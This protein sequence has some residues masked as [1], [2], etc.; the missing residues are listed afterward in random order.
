MTTSITIVTPRARA[1]K[2]VRR[3]AD[4]HKVAI[5]DLLGETKLTNV[6]K[7]RKEAYV[8]VAE[9]MHWWSV[10]QVAKFFGRDHTTVLH[11]FNVSGYE[12]GRKSGGQ[13]FIRISSLAKENAERRAECAA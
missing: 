3:I 2:V 12:H 5:V 10:F 13:T 11:A 7:A 6:L 8:A 9:E 1:M 4:K